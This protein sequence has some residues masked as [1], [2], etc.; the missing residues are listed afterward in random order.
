MKKYLL[1]IG[2]ILIPVVV[3]AWGILGISGGGGVDPLLLGDSDFG[4]KAQATTN[5]ARCRAFQGDGGTYSYGYFYGYSSSGTETWYMGLYNASGTP[6]DPTT[7]IS[8]GCS[9]QGTVRTDGAGGGWNEVTFTPGITLSNGTWY[10][11][12]PMPS[13]NIE[14]WRESGSG[15]TDLAATFSN[16]E[17]DL[18]GDT[19]ESSYID[20]V[21]VTNYD[22]TP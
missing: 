14:Y 13:G 17:A 3:Y 10:F 12:C 4:S 1:I 8:N 7:L 22:Y 9:N 11:M 5:G 15:V 2:I 16:C 19:A 18:T 6:G 21:I 20:A